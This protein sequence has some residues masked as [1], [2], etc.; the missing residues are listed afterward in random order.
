LF[1]DFVYPVLLHVPKE[2]IMKKLVLA[3]GALSLV[4][5]SAPALASPCKDAKGRFVKCPAKPKVCR[6]SKGHYVKCKR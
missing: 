5:G 2:G 6:D 3:L 1:K 4:A